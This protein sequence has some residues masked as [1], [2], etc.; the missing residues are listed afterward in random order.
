MRPTWSGEAPV[1]MP[2]EIEYS[3]GTVR[4]EFSRDL[5]SG[6]CSVRGVYVFK[7]RFMVRGGR[8]SSCITERCGKRTLEGRR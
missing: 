7:R 3:L 5:I 2:L 1:M 8:R 4:P 6:T